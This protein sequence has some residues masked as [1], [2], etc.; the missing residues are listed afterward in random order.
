MTNTTK[1]SETL[2]TRINGLADN[3]VID[4][5]IIFSLPPT[6]DQRVVLEANTA[7]FGMLRQWIFRSRLTVASLDPITNLEC[8]STIT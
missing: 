6:S 3:A 8:V 2:K 1:F 7:T 4:V 5:I